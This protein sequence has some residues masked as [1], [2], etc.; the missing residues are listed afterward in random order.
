[1]TFF[2]ITYALDVISRPGATSEPGNVLIKLPWD[3]PQCL[4]EDFS[5]HLCFVQLFNII[6]NT[7]ILLSGL[8]ELWWWKFCLSFI[9]LVVLEKQKT[10]KCP[11]LALENC[12][13]ASVKVDLFISEFG[14]EKC[15]SLWY[16][17]HWEERGNIFIF[18]KHTICPKHPR[19]FYLSVLTSGHNWPFAELCSS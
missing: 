8:S 1:M 13:H 15:C 3:L 18:T 11:S 10:T 17:H 6:E 12:I 5:L 16:L 9:C 14:I 4:H 7:F 2:Q 19:L